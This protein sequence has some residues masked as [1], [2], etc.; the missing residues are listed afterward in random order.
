MSEVDALKKM[1]IK[2]IVKDL[3]NIQ[4]AHIHID[5]E[6]DG[7]TKASLCGRGVDIK[8]LAA[9]INLHVIDKC[10]EFVDE[11]FDIMKKFCKFEKI[12]M[13]MPRINLSR[14]FVRC[15]KI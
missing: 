1:I 10:G 6:K 15:S 9:M 3:M 8:F 5:L 7:N 13:I 12:R 14:S 4:P 2:N 11:Y